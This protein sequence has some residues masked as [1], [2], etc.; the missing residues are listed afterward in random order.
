LELTLG[1]SKKKS[2][3]QLKQ[4]Y[5]VEV[6]RDKE[7]YLRPHLNIENVWKLDFDKEREELLPA[8]TSG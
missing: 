6:V 7:T 8:F 2:K 4:Y 1:N 5:E 3:H